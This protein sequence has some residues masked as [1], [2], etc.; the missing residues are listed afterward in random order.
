M[1]IKCGARQIWVY[2]P[3]LSFT[4]SE[5]WKVWLCDPKPQFSHLQNGDNNAKTLK[6][7]KEN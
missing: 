2:V 3:A 5:A 6:G 7:Y 4:S 1:V